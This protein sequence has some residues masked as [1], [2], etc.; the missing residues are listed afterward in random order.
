LEYFHADNAFRINKNRL[1]SGLLQE[2]TEVN[3]MKVYKVQVEQTT[4]K[5]KGK[6]CFLVVR[7]TSDHKLTVP[8]GY[9][10]IA[11]LEAL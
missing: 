2:E 8:R 10:L 1:V 4:G 9:K 3:D 6:K 7:E 5:N 11:I